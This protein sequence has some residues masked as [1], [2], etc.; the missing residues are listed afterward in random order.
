MSLFK[1]KYKFVLHLSV[2]RIILFLSGGSLHEILKVVI[3]L[4]FLH[5][6]C[7]TEQEKCTW[8]MKYNHP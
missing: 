5:E 7:V 3:G 6:W 2:C 8:Q 4:N 1:L